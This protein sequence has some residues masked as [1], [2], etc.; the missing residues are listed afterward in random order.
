MLIVK[1]YA[2][3]PSIPLPRSNSNWNFSINQIFKNYICVKYFSSL[4]T[5]VFSIFK[6]LF[7]YLYYLILEH[8]SP[9]PPK[10][11]IPI[12]NH[13]PL[14]LPASS[15]QPLIFLSLWICLF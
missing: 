14:F 9:P 10:K 11:P 2:A 4:Q 3:L 1:R 5:V 13:S 8:L 6:E 15:W 7:I 12:N